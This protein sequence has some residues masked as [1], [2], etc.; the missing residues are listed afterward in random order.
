[1]LVTINVLTN[2]DVV[3]IVDCD[4]VAQLQVTRS[5]SRLTCNT[6]HSTAIAEEAVC[7]V[8][9]KLVA[10][11]IE[12]RRGVSLSYGQPNSIGETLAERTSCD[13]DT[14][15]VVGLGVTGCDAIK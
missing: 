10:I 15:G 12:G 2:G 6:L 5:A 11:L 3:V 13:L 8:V 4:E 14:G 1:M 9:D 7:V